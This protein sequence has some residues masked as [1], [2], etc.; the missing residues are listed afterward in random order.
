[1]KRRLGSVQTTNAELELGDFM[2]F[3]VVPDADHP[4]ITNEGMVYEGLRH[5]VSCTLN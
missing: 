1:L 3:S 5:R 4:A 2:V